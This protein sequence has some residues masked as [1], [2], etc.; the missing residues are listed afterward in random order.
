M[1]EWIQNY[2]IAE[3]VRDPEGLR[4]R[5]LKGRKCFGTYLVTLSATP[6]NQL[7]FFAADQLRNPFRRSHCPPVVGI[8]HSRESA[9]GLV[10]R[11][12]ED[13]ARQSGSYDA[14]SYLRNKNC[15]RGG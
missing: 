4:R 9:L 11:I 14:G 10:V 13:C 5:I 2:Y 3:G 8:A 15:N 12:I 1:P 6:G 7:E